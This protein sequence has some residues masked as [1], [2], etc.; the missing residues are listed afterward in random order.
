MPCYKPLKGFTDAK[1]QGSPAFTMSQDKQRMM[2]LPCGQCIG[3]RLDHAKQWAVRCMHEASM[4]DDNAFL[5]LTY[6]PEHYPDYGALNYAHFQSFMKRLRSKVPQKLR[7]FMCGEYGEKLERPH[8]HAL[9]FG[10]WPHDAE[11]LKKSD[12]GHGIYTS[13]LLDDTWQKGHVFVGSVDYESAGYCARYSMK[14]VKLSDASPEEKLS[15]YE[16]TLPDGTIYYLPPEFMR[17]SL[18]PGIGRSWYDKY[19]HDDVY[20][21]DEVIV[22]GRKHKPPRYY[23]KLL[24]EDNPHLHE[25][26]TDARKESAASNWAETRPSRLAT[27]QECTERRSQQL[28]RSYEK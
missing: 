9:I 19:A 5:T 24:K 28:V 14:K 4:H 10:L 22:R 20:P 21:Q 7:F 12:S 13:N 8:Y 25:I 6:A 16:R 23:D 1:G 18:K 26:I 3:C 2:L 15:H 27:K 17:C 11:Y